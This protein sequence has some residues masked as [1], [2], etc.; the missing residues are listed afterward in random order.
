MIKPWLQFQPKVKL[1]F[2]KFCETMRRETLNIKWRENNWLLKRG[3]NSY[4]VVPLLKA[5]P[6]LNHSV[7]YLMD[8]CFINVFMCW[9]FLYM[10]FALF[11]FFG[12]VFCSF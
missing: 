3:C 4:L 1:C 7:A 9:L 10:Y 6:R 12:S 2:E 8:L 5:G 11:V